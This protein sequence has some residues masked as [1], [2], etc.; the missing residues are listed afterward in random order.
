MKTFTARALRLARDLRLPRVGIV[1]NAADAAPLVGKAVEGAVIG[2]YTFD[3]YKQEKDEFLQKE[4]QL[5]V[6][7][8]PDH[9]ADAEARKSRY[10][11]VSENVNLARDLINEPGA[12]VTPAYLADRAGEIAKEV[13]LRGRDPRPRGAQGARLRGHAARGPGQRQPPA[14]GHP[15][16][17]APQGRRRRRWRSSARASPSTPAASASSPATA[18][19]R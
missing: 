12:V 7:V 16:P 10:A 6:L 8:H 14:H 3:R 1:L 9:S 19:G 5:V 13:G 18:C 17:R 2:A 11:W 4:A 15:A